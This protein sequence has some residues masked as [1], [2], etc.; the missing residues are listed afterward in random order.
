MLPSI[1]HKHASGAVLLV[2]LWCLSILCLRVAPADAAT[3]FAPDLK[4][5]TL[6]TPHFE[7]HYYQGLEQTARD[8]ADIAEHM[9]RRLSGRIGWTPG[10]RTHL[11]LDDQTDLANGSATPLPHN[12]ITLNITPPAGDQGLALNHDRW[13]EMLVLHEYTHILHLDRVEGAPGV[14]RSLLGRFPLAFPNVFNP[15]WMTEGLATYEETEGTTGGRG[16][17]AL[18]AGML[19]TQALEGKLYPVSVASHPVHRWP[20]GTTRYLYG[21]DFLRYLAEKYG[22]Q[23]VPDLVTHYSNNLIPYIVSGNVYHTVGTNL[24]PAWDDWRAQLTVK[25]QKEAIGRTHAGE[26][27]TR[28]GFHTRGPRISPD[29]RTVAFTERTQRDHTRILLMPADGKTPVDDGPQRELAWRNTGRALAWLDDGKLLFSQAEFSGTYRLRNDLYTLSVK[30]GKV[31]RLTRGARLREADVRPD[32]RV[33]AVQNG[34]PEPGDTALVLLNVN[35]KRASPPTALLA[36]GGGAIFSHPRFSPDGKTVAVSLQMGD[37]RRNVVRVDVKS[38]K[39]TLVT[40][41]SARDAD[42]AWSPGG[43]YLLFSSD[44]TGTF[45]LFAQDLKKGRLYQVT[46]VPGGALSPEISP[47]GKTIYYTGL[48]GDGFDLYRMRFEPASWKPVKAQAATLA[49]PS[50]VEHVD[51]PRRDRKYNAS[52]YLFPTTWLPISYVEGETGYLGLFTGG[53]DPLG[54]HQY[55]LQGAWSVADRVGEGIL[56]YQYDRLR[57]TVQITLRQNLQPPIFICENPPGCTVVNPIWLNDQS[58]AMDLIFPF[59]KFNRIRHLILG[60][61][62]ENHDAINRCTVCTVNRWQENYLRLGLIHSSAQKYGLGIS[63]T[64][65]RRISLTTKL[66]DE[67]WGSDLEGRISQLDW[68][69]FISLGK[70]G[71]V[72]YGRITRAEATRNLLLAVGGPPDFA[73]SAFDSSFALRGYPEGSFVGDNVARSTLALR[74]PLSLVEWGAGSLPLF[75]EKLHL[76]LIIEGAQ[77]RGTSGYWDDA[78]GSA[79]ELGTDLAVGYFLPLTLRFGTAWGMGDRGE[80]QTYIKVEQAFF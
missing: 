64:D 50:Q 32:G 23:T 44:R 11:I 29:G 80:T 76:A 6:T 25:S 37:G 36:P 79:V 58:A 71:A 35:G 4:W 61:S 40:L 31:R 27:L 21:E 51:E 49:A 57:P 22:K 45:N 70:N 7:V 9:H 69:E 26:R 2:T 42:P 59:R 72:L 14:L 60:T 68:K 17:G 56:I 65:G 62:T 46:N 67:Q 18:Y 43:R 10:R 30:N 63:Q 55:L 1:L 20:A 28:S 3:R 52:R 77:I 8:A 48:S 53:A 47:D 16:R 78:F 75:L 74:L 54:R 41:G 12:I 38:S 13:L 34:F 66:A 39:V 24:I 5:R 33:V 15:V 19:R 73:E